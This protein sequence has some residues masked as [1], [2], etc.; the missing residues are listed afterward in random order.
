MSGTNNENTQTKE[1]TKMMK[2]LVAVAAIA[3]A[4]ATFGAPAPSATPP[5]LDELR[6][7]ANEVRAIAET[8]AVLAQRLVMGVVNP[9]N[10]PKR[11]GKEVDELRAAVDESFDAVGLAGPGHWA[12]GIDC[13]FP[14]IC[15]RGLESSGIATNVPHLYALAVK[16]GKWCKPA[17]FTDR[18]ATIEE[19]VGV[20]N[21]CLDLKDGKCRMLYTYASLEKIRKYIQSGCVRPV[22]KY[23]VSQGRPFVTKDGVNPCE[24]YMTEL[25]TALNA[26]YF[27]GLNAWF[28]KIGIAASVDVSHLPPRDH[29]ERLRAAILGADKDLTKDDDFVLKVCLG[30]EGYNAFVRKYNGEE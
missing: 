1:N 26:P 5:T 20:L 25:N 9:L 29:V 11:V 14:K 22:K 15:R 16:Y 4:S 7:K 27:D 13:R 28:A 2:Q 19:I 21:E 8:N 17:A 23:L 6:A 3:L 10:N 24:T 18:V 12:T 30:V